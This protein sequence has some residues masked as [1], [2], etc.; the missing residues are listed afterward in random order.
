M[1]ERGEKYMMVWQGEAWGSRSMGPS[2][3]TETAKQGRKTGQS[4]GVGESESERGEEIRAATG[5]QA[6]RGKEGRRE[7]GREGFRT[8]S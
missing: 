5:R 7:S 4:A 8:A 1:S 3:K 6:G 2:K